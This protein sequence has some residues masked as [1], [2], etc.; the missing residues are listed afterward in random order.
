MKINKTNNGRRIKSTL[1][2]AALMSA[3]GAASA[4]PVSLT[5]DY[6]CTYPLIGTQPLTIHVTSDM[7]ETINV[8][9]S[10]GAYAIDA[11]ATLRGM[12][13]TGLNIVSAASLEG[14]AFVTSSISGNNFNTDMVVV[15]GITQQPIPPV[16][17][18]FDLNASG[19]SD[20]LTFDSSN[21]GTMS[22]TVGEMNMEILA[23]KAD[24]TPVIFA[25]SDPETGI[26]P[27]ACTQLPDQD[28]VLHTFEV[29]EE[30]AE[31]NISVS[32]DQV[33]FGNVLAG[34]MPSAVITISNTG[35]SPLG[36]NN[37][38]LT[39]ADAGLFVET[40]DC[41]TVD[42]GSSCQVEVTYL[43]SGDA[44]HSAGLVIASTDEDEPSISVPLTG[45]SEVETSPE[46]SVNPMSV[47][48]LRVAVG[49]AA[50]RSVTV[51]NQGTQELNV[52]AIEVSGANASDFV[53]SHDC[54]MLQPEDT[55]S[56]DVT[57]TPP[58]DGVYSAALNV[59]S[60]DPENPQV[61]VSLVGEG[62]T[63][64]GNAIEISLDLVGETHIV[65]AGGVAPLTGSIEAL[66]DLATGIY[67][68]DLMLDPTSGDFPLLGS[69]LGTSAVIAFE[70]VGQTTGMLD[71][72]HLTAESEMYVLLPKI[73]VKMFGLKI[74]IGGGDNCRT[75]DPVSMMLESPD[76]EVFDP[77]QTGGTIEGEYTL[78]VVEQCG[79]FT[80]IVNGLMA[81]EG[82]T[83]SLQ[84]TPASTQ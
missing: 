70:Q 32:P 8:G 84:L 34:E 6:N 10:T 82:N 48:F 51:S 83:L 2:A 81:G 27:S 52:T 37:I 45:T 65:T 78:P 33:D 49:S 36:I 17:G 62:F 72:G 39:G 28:T 46:I 44:T 19:E 40:N 15:A 22:I 18:D 1:A 24:G 21:V 73:Y 69:F 74:R 67:T 9:E 25:E 80:G 68:A 47:D 12:T 35:G 77:L 71:Q 29:I 76:G 61:S 16:N 79:L 59:Q 13:W 31:A 63:N 56:V 57:F 43:A 60:D 38:S 66:F 4:V 7:P 20:P 11:V 54:G 53:A 58:A 75:M 50:S 5:L 23:R 64:T 42:A 55:C 3:C 30:V 14:E 26:F 41:T